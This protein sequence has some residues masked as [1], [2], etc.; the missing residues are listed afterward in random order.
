MKNVLVFVYSITFN[1]ITIEK[2]QRSFDVDN[3]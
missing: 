3:G 2:K 1:F